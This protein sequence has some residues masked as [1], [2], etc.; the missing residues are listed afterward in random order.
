MSNGINREIEQLIN[1]FTDDYEILKE[2]GY[3]EVEDAVERKEDIERIFEIINEHGMIFSQFMKDNEN[4][5]QRFRFTLDLYL[6]A[7][8][9][10]ESTM[11]KAKAFAD[12][13]QA[14]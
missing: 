10:N 8:N 14:V 6:R 1:Y 3:M 11:F 4:L 5:F 7:A 9:S 13:L 12:E 2:D